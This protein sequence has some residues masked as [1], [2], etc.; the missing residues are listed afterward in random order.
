MRRSLRIV[1]I[2]IA[3]IAVVALILVGGYQ[4]LIRRSFPQ[5]SGTVA[6]NGLNA[7]VTI[8][9]DAN[10]IPHVY[11]DN[12]E[13]LYF[14]QGYLHAQERFWQME[15]QRHIGGGRLSEILGG[16]TLGTDIYLRTLGFQQ[17]A[18]QEYAMFDDTTKASL[19]S[20]TAGVNAYISNRSPH[21]LALEF[22]VLMI[23]AQWTVE[24]WKPTD[25][26]LWVHMMIYDQGDI[27]ETEYRNLD[28]LQTVGLEL[29]AQLVPPYP[30]RHP[31]IV[32]DGSQGTGSLGADPA[33]TYDFTPE[34]IAVLRS[35]NLN[36]VG[37]MRPGQLSA[38]LNNNIQMGSNSWVVG[39]DHTTTG[40]PIMANDPHMSIQ[41]PS[42]WYQIGLHCNTKSESCLQNME[43]AS[44]PGVPGIL[45]GHNDRISWAL[46]NAYFDAEDAYIE[47]INPDNP[48]QYEVNGKW[49]D[50][51][52][53]REEIKIEGQ[54]EPYILLVRSTRHG[55]IATDNMMP[56]RAGFNFDEE[57]QQQLYAVAFSWTALS[58]IRTL[59]AVGKINIAQN[60]NDF[61]SALEEFDAGKQNLLYAD[62]DGNIGYQL[63]G[64]IPIRAKGDGSLPVP[65]WTDEYE[66]TGFI[67]YDDLPRTFN[68]DQGFIVTANNPQVLDTYKYLLSTE[69]DYGYR[70]S[71][72]T[73]MI[74]AF[75]ESG[76]LISMDEMQTIQRDNQ[77]LS[78][79][80]VIPY[81]ENI[82]FDDQK[83]TTARDSLLDWDAQMITTS[84]EAALYSYFW[85][86]LMVDLFWDQ[87]PEGARP[88]GN[89]RASEILY[90]LL[91]DEDNPYW[92]DVFTPDQETRDD[93]L[94]RSFQGGYDQ[95]VEEL[96]A[97]LS[98]WQWGESHTIRLVERP[99]GESGI[100]LIES[101]FNR[102][103]FPVSGAEAVVNK[104]AWNTNNDDF[105]ATS[106]PAVRAIYD[107]NDFSNSL[108]I[109]C[110]GQSGHPG[111]TNYDDFI[112]KWL[113]F[114]YNQTLWTRQNVEAKAR[115]K[116][117][118]EPGK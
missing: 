93:I 17:L 74:Q 79:L 13:D 112:Q 40:K 25:S 31:V 84:P 23:D 94:R 81:L 106:A 45:L 80:E 97:D 100:D 50:M 39:G 58:P 42:L 47:R 60:W 110:G 41:I 116:L 61:R 87:L 20:Y 113:N 36:L 14:A 63:P 53:R 111:H 66:W 5:S 88:G 114:E 6:L 10:G 1:G 37:G 55:P 52:I 24:P 9:R 32:S 33:T 27:M 104:I 91:Q 54:D 56:E 99:L 102:G 21:D 7:P 19:D 82:K 67:P 8:Y 85:K 30:D 59:E 83:Y 115:D 89:D 44:L 57:G 26:L 15:F 90:H 4:A 64:K 29:G 118:L 51:E 11:A 71:R 108:M 117:V 68:P 48:N 86:N 35:I 95:G 69:K 96:G 16:R 77:S 46:T 22:S 92:D 73:A 109:F 62:V 18:E 98:R 105:H 101:I 28:A 38:F 65:G 72:I 76:K 107:L 34:E 12:P 49:V 3:I 2:V 78:A 75:I 70:A 43:G 103:P